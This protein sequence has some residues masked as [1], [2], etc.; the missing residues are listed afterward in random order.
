[1]RPMA[2]VEGLE[3]F[4]P[5]FR[6]DYDDF[7]SFDAI[8]HVVRSSVHVLGESY[9]SV[10]RCAFCEEDLNLNRRPGWREGWG[11]A[12]YSVRGRVFF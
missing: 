5:A 12:S 3:W 4:R 6:I 1:M 8:N 9:F 7:C 2:A 10:H 11:W